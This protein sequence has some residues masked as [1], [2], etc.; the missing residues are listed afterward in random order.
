MKTDYLSGDKRHAYE[1][2]YPDIVR[3]R[4]SGE[5]LTGRR[6]FPHR[7][8]KFGFGYN[9]GHIFVNFTAE[10]RPFPAVDIA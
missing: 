2:G 5:N 1:A 6:D 10:S 9:I 4:T 3:S 7:K 8:T